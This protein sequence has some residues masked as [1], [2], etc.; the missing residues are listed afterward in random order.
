ML[1]D[2][3]QHLPGCQYILAERAA[4]EFDEVVPVAW[5]ASG[6]NSEASTVA[7]PM[8]QGGF[9]SERVT[10]RE[11]GHGDHPERQVGD[12]HGD[13]QHEHHIL[14]RVRDGAA[15]ELDQNVIELVV[16]DAGQDAHHAY[17]DEL[18]C[19]WDSERAIPATTAQ[20]LAKP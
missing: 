15:A 17:Q 19:S 4:G 11:H 20:S 12:V 13:V 14:A 3:G 5:L 1:D 7:L 18:A 10:G 9:H 2:V 16:A 8:D 6:T